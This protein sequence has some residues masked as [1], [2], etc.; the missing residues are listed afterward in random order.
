VALQLAQIAPMR[1]RER[2]LF[3]NIHL[4]MQD[5]DT[6]DAKLRGSIDH[7]FDEDFGIAEMPIRIGADTQ[8]DALS[9]LA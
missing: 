7:S 6:L 3:G 2:V 8:L 1:L 4:T 9:A 5:V